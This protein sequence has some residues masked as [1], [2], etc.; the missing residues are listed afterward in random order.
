[1]AGTKSK[2]L[3]QSMESHEF[4]RIISYYATVNNAT[5]LMSKVTVLD[6]TITYFNNSSS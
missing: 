5:Q 4:D 2:V 3:M 1:V 6:V